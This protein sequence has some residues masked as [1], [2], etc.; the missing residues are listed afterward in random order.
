MPSTSVCSCLC[1]P[2]GY[3]VERLEIREL[4]FHFG[5]PVQLHHDAAGFVGSHLE[6]CALFAIHI[7]FH[8]TTETHAPMHEAIGG[9]L[10]RKRSGVVT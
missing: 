2:M 1:M 6:R 3:S 4:D 10:A 8:E 7:T 9:V 5:P